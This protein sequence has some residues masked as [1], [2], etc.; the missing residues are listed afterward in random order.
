MKFNEIQKNGTFV[1]KY[2][3]DLDSVYTQN[4]YEVTN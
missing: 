4:I 3:F 1:E 2:D